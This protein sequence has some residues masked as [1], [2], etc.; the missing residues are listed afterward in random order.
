ME[1]LKLV[2]PTKEYE[3]QVMYYKEAF[4]KN[5]D[6]FAGCAGLEEIQCYDEWI[7]F[8]KRL[9]KKYGKDYVPSSV[10]LA[11]RK[12]DN[13]VVV[14][15][16][17]RHNLSEFLKNKGE[18]IGYSILPEERKKGY[19]KEMLKLM[20]LKCKELKK[21]KVLITCDKQNIASAKTILAN[22]G[23]LENEVE[24]KFNMGKSGTIQR[25]WIDLR[26]K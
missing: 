17:F 21:E 20:L 22:G 1:R 15:I 5:N 26:D 6:N 16:D 9:S 25:Y 18:N 4:I 19:A 24:D 23:V 2:I 12:E 11:V 7:D 8:E 10:Y 14:I 3:D 13:K